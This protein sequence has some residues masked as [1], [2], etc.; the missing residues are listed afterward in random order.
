MKD[1]ELTNT[2]KIEDYR[3]APTPEWWDKTEEQWRVWAEGMA[4]I[5]DIHALVD[6]INANGGEI[7]IAYRTFDP[8]AMNQDGHSGIAGCRTPLDTL[9]E[10]DLLMFK[11]MIDR[12]IDK[13]LSQK[14]SE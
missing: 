5:S 9:S 13:K 8:V 3:N 2:K 1:D 6:K 4:L 10:Y 7:V 11:S 12:I 14:N